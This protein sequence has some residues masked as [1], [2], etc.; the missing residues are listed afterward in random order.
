MVAWLTRLAK[1]LNKRQ[2]CLFQNRYGLS[3]RFRTYADRAMLK[4]QQEASSAM[5]GPRQTERSEGLLGYSR[6]RT[7]VR[8]RLNGSPLAERSEVKVGNIS[9]TAMLLT[10]SSV[11]SA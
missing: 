2:P 9:S 8:N 5:R 1:T 4:W 11:R 6:A 10:I 7:L 3:L